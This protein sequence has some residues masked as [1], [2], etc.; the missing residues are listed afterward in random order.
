MNREYSGAGISF[1]YP[2]HWELLAEPGDEQ[3]TIAVSDGGTSLWSITLLPDRPQAEHVLRTAI[4]TFCE[5][6]PQAE[7]QRSEERL[8]RRPVLTAELEFLCLELVNQV[9]L[10]AFRTGR[11]TVLLMAQSTDHEF[12]AVAPVFAA[13]LQS[14][15]CDRDGEI[16]IR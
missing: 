11:F 14:L 10:R 7:V 12:A 6:Y 13:I 9:T 1:R 4:S 8:G 15:D 3:T 2:A 16:T 5:E